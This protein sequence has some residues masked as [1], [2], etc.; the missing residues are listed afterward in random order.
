MF[1]L[2]PDGCVSFAARSVR[3]R[4]YMALFAVLWLMVGVPARAQEDPEAPDISIGPD[5]GTYSIAAS[6]RE[7]A[8][9]A[10]GQV[11]EAT[12]IFTDA[13]GMNKDSLQVSISSPGE[14]VPVTR[15]AWTSNDPILARAKYTF[16]LVDKGDHVLNVSIAD[17]SGRVGTRRATFRLVYT[18]PAVPIVSLAPH[19]NEYRNTTIGAA[20][21]DYSLPSYTSLGVAR[22]LGLRYDSE[23]ADPTAFVQLDADVRSFPRAG[24]SFS[25]TIVDPS[26][27]TRVTPETFWTMSTA[28]RQRLAAHWSMSGRPTGAYMYRA[29]V[30]AYRADGTVT[31]T[32]VPIRILVVNHASSHYGSGWNIAGIA[33]IHSVDPLTDDGFLLEEGNGVARWFDKETNGY[34]EH[35]Y[36][37]PRGDFSKIVYNRVTNQWVRTYPDGSVMT[38]AGR[39]QGLLIS[40]SDRFGRTTTYSWQLTTDGQNVPVLAHV[41]DPAGKVTTLAYHWGYLKEIVAPGNRRVTLGYDHA[42]GL[43]KISGPHSVANLDVAY[44]AGYKVASYT[45]ARGTWTITYDPFRRV[46]SLSAPG[47]TVGGIAGQRPETRFTSLEAALVPTAPCAATRPGCAA[48]PPNEV[49]VTIEDPG[50]HKT[51][52]AT[53]RYGLPVKVAGPSGMVVT[54]LRTADGLPTE[55]WTPLQT[56]ISAWNA[57]GQQL[58]EEVNGVVV[59]H[60]S[61]VGDHYEYVNSRD[62]ARWYRYGARGELLKTWFG[63]QEDSTRTA[64]VYT[65]DSSYRLVS[66]AGPN[67]ERTEWSYDPVWQNV[68]EVRW[69]HAGGTWRKQT[70]AYDTFGRQVSTTNPLGE[71]TLVEY[72]VLNRVIKTTQ[73]SRVTTFGYTGPDLTSVT[74]PGGK[75]YGYQYNALGW[76]EKETFPD[77]KSRSATYDIDGLLAS[78]TDRRKRPVKY[79]YDTSHRLTSLLADGQTTSRRSIFITYPAAYVP[80]AEIVA[81]N[82]EMQESFGF[83]NSGQI[84]RTTNKIGYKSY[85]ME[86]ILD[87]FNGWEVV[88]LDLRKYYDTFLLETHYLRYQREYDLAD[89][90]LLSA[91]HIDGYDNKRTSLEFDTSGRHVR[92]KFA[93]G[94]TQEN[95]FDIEGRR[96][97]TTFTPLASLSASYSYDALGRL[98]T[99]TA[100]SAGKL[101]QYDQY[102]QLKLFQ[103]TNWNNVSGWVPSYQEQYAYDLAGNRTDRGATLEA[104]SNRYRTFDEYTLEYDAE[105]NVTRKYRTGFDQRFEW[106]ALGQLA[107]VT[108][109]GTTVTYGYTPSGLRFRRTEG[110]VSRYYVYLDGDLMLELDN[111]A[112]PSRR[113]AHLPGTDVPLSVDTIAATNNSHYFA[114]DHPGH[115]SALMNASGAITTNYE[116]TPFGTETAANDG[117][118][119]RYMAREL[120]FS[121]GL[122]YVRARWY[123]PT[124]ARFVSEDPIGLAGGMNTYAYAGNDPINGRDPSGLDPCDEEKN[125]MNDCENP[126]VLDEVVVVARR[127]HGSSWFGFF[128]FEMNTASGRHAEITDNGYYGYA[129]T[130]LGPAPRDP[131]NTRGEDTQRCMAGAPLQSAIQG[132]DQIKEVVGGLAAGGAL[133]R[134]YLNTRRLGNHL[135]RIRGVESLLSIPDAPVAKVGRRS[136]AATARSLTALRTR[137]V[138]AGPYVVAGTWAVT[139]GV[140]CYSE[141]ANW[142]HLP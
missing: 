67:G 129:K 87:A 139:S 88:G 47:I 92:T 7:E 27:N 136:T 75:V 73:A 64:T 11:V 41:T 97:G 57:T 53:D 6:T 66:V 26:T 55:I 105:G 52:I 5:G 15:V 33:R 36:R 49:Y 81:K 109:N 116:Y 44:E 134:E 79:E 31:L 124:L 102:G 22:S 101:Y 140:R 71:T 59:F 58:S 32:Q 4:L 113:Y 30:R 34:P 62:E 10:G 68:S 63:K 108:T 23:Q 110:G 56:S 82:G 72:D 35:T 74:V 100:G 99:R 127:R 80:G 77:G 104:G 1:T 17:K 85:V 86:K 125:T 48:V 121:T 126:I 112:N 3:S 118:P 103:R 9:A 24:A 50:K 98:S 25:L 8:D 137:A 107:S 114:L 106:D 115:V 96:T 14:L 128:G 123:D 18:D 130:G 12:L 132:A 51:N 37:T 42:T 94:V 83:G 43:T 138:Y 111:D 20:T 142:D 29:E 84:V 19:H 38:F 46:Q 93:N 39:G 21:L 70:F 131:G 60:G 54:T 76:L 122:Y 28:G 40:T 45:D 135:T 13:D 91:F 89:P 69:L 65:Y 119:L 2:I 120:D 141:S 16:K 117:Q 133:L 61:V 90:T 95:V 78:Q